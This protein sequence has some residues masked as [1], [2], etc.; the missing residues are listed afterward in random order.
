MA[1]DQNQ[2]AGDPP[3]QRVDQEWLDSAAAEPPEYS[4]DAPQAAQALRQSGLPYAISVGCFVTTNN[5]EAEAPEEAAKRIDP[6]SRS[7]LYD[8][9][10]IIVMCSASA[11]EAFASWCDK[12]LEW[13]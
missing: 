6:G 4:D 12:N 10:L 2:T 3:W 13:L 11:T 9:G 5:D 7:F 8:G 1:N